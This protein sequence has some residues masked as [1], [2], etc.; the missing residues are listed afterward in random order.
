MNENL[1]FW[2]TWH[3]NEKLPLFIAFFLITILL[4]GGVFAYLKGLENIIHWDVLSELHEKIIATNSFFYDE[5][6]FSASTPLW[7]I[8]ER[9]MPSLVE[10][11]TLA[12]YILLGGS[13]VGLSLLLTG[14]ARL[15][16]LWFLIGALLLGG[17]FIGMHT[18]IKS[19]Q[20]WVTIFIFCNPYME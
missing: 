17:V 1:N 16:G 11:N 2:R 14:L 12:F 19:G 3:K 13:L 7:Y 15:K 5:F 9:Y 20:I 4:L 8:K 18:E 10:V 6:K